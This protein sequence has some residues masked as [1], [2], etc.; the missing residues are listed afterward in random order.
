MSIF[1]IEKFL[2]KDIKNRQD[3]FERGEGKLDNDAPELHSGKE[4]YYHRPGADT[5]FSEFVGSGC[6]SLNIGVDIES[7]DYSALMNG[8]N[9]RTC[10]SF[11]SDT[12]RG[13]LDKGNANAG[14][15]T[16]FNVDKSISLLYASLPREQQLN[17]ERAIMESSRRTIE[18]A[19]ELGYFGYRTGSSNSSELKKHKDGKIVAATFLHFTNR[20][21]EPHLHVHAEIPNLVLG[22]DG[23]WRTIDASDLYRRQVEFAALYDCYLAEAIK[24]DLPE[25][26]KL[27]ESDPEQNGLRVAGVTR[28]T[29]MQFSSRRAEILAGLSEMA[30]SGPVSARA[31]AKRSRDKKK[32]IDANQLRLQWKSALSH[33]KDQ[34]TEGDLSP[35]TLLVAEQLLLK[36]GSVFDDVALDRAAAQLAVLH[37]GINAIPIVKA[38]LVSQLKV[39]AL[40]GQANNSCL[41]TTEAY[42]DMESDLLAWSLKAQV[43]EQRYALRDDIID[44]AIGNFE[45]AK[46]FRMRMEQLAAVKHCTRGA[47][48]QILNGAA[49]TGKSASLTAVRMAY[50]S[51][52]KRVIG[53]APSGAAAAELEKSAGIT[54]CTIH[55]LLLRLEN[56]NPSQT[57]KLS[58]ND[59]IIC[60]EAG[61]AD[62][63]TLHKLCKLVE[64]AGSKLILAGD[65]KQLESVGSASSLQMLTDE[66]GSADLIQIARQP[67]PNER[68][69]SQTWYSGPLQEGSPDALELMQKHGLLRTC[70]KSN[71]TAL[72]LLLAEAAEI[73]ASGVTWND[74]LILA[75][76][77]SQVSTLNEKVRDIRKSLGELAQE[78]EI[79]VATSVNN[80]SREIDISVNDRV[81]LRK[82]GKVGSDEI[83]VYNGDKGTVTAL[84]KVQK[85]FDELGDPI[86]DVQITIR[87]DRSG[88]LATWNLSDYSSLEHGYAMTVHKSQGLTVD[89]A[90]YLPSAMS[91]RRLAYVAYTRSRN[92]CRFYLENDAETKSD[93]YKNTQFFSTK[94]TALDSDEQLKKLIK[95]PSAININNNHVFRHPNMETKVLLEKA[96]D[97]FIYPVENLHPAKLA[98]EVLVVHETY[99]E[100]IVAEGRGYLVT[101]LLDKPNDARDRPSK[102]YKLIGTERKVMLLAKP[103]NQINPRLSVV[104][105]NVNEYRFAEH[106]DAVSKPDYGF[107][108]FKRFGDPTRKV[109]PFIKYTP[110]NNTYGTYRETSR[111][112]LLKLST[113]TLAASKKWRS[114]SILHGDEATNR[115]AS[116]RMRRQSA[117]P[118][119]KDALKNNEE[120]SMAGKRVWTRDKQRAETQAIRDRIDL[121]DYAKS[122]GYEQISGAGARVRLVNRTLAKGDAMHE[123][124]LKTGS[125]GELTWIAVKAGQGS[126][127][128]GDIFHLHQHFSQSTFLEARDALRQI[129]FGTT[130]TSVDDFK[131]ISDQAR[132]K[133]IAETKAKEAEQEEI[134]RGL[135][136]AI[137]KKS[138][139]CTNAFLTSR[140]ISE[141][142]LAETQWRTDNY[143][144]AVFVHERA[145]G[146]F[147]GFERKKNGPPLYSKSLRGI[148]VAN[149]SS[150]PT[151]VKICVSEGGLDALSL[152]QLASP[153]DRARTIYVSSAGNPA[154]DTAKALI[155][156]AERVRLQKIEL[157]Y[158]NDNA[159]NQHTQQLTNLLQQLAPSLHVCDIR[160]E[161]GM[162]EGEDPNDVLKR[163]K[164]NDERDV[165]INT[166]GLEETLKITDEDEIYS[167]FESISTQPLN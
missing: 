120:N 145:D 141:K 96:G 147:T 8:I 6:A 86:F 23:I 88:E 83:S 126:K 131:A 109:T 37:G 46:G 135:A 89:Y 51:A 15:S 47:R 54:S 79:R 102:P 130:H 136:Y 9:P 157:A 137:Y 14:F 160:A 26:G 129:A 163:G 122:L 35:A 55:S 27:L 139:R 19:E 114:P 59:V 30:A 85:G 43:P 115:R 57:F 167:Y 148:Y 108:K 22:K 76:R 32:D 77:N 34:I 61:L 12:R 48:L 38:A 90:L 69:I 65:P 24:R 119:V 81:L 99:E 101:N 18:K 4:D 125:A 133:R 153:E 164:L 7:G 20:A 42:R 97:R 112:G 45:L 2:V 128:G 36:G 107:G 73:H 142:T 21:Q 25:L 155:G 166:I 152:Y 156:L 134:R 5:I 100:K 95:T 74:V 72:D 56:D 162:V 98:P 62:L 116:T 66:I 124:I 68:E 53:L 106:D 111:N 110:L 84:R 146:K 161:I 78:S 117:N 151:A 3:Y 118:N 104:Q 165:R 143:G 16:S 58:E 28:D 113:C 17:I 11:V 87:F 41:Y 80:D 92:G 10:E 60:D 144:N 82:N 154:I 40:P 150:K 50:E 140:G 105:E 93:F 13:Q 33:L 103:F 71:E 127:L 75:D 123:I 121:A 63:R 138:T 158:D 39:L 94:K 52:G 64:D 49:G 31:I 91:N 67:D 44:E 149:P 159:G 70:T 29:I 132:P 1:T